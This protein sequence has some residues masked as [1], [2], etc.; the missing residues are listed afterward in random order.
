MEKRRFNKGFTLIELIV[1]IAILGILVLIAAPK[2]LGYVAEAEEAKIKHDVKVMEQEME[3]TSLEIEMS[4]WQTNDKD[5]S[6]LIIENKLFEKQGVAE[7]IDSGHVQRNGVLLES[8]VDN[9][10]ASAKDTSSELGMGGDLIPIS[11]EQSASLFSASASSFDIDEFNISKTYKIIPDEYKGEIDTSLDGTFYT[12]SEK[13]VYYEAGIASSSEKE[14]TQ[15]NLDCE[16]AAPDYD[17]EMVGDF[18]TITK[19]YGTELN[20]DIPDSFLL[21]VDGEEECVPVTVIGKA[22][23]MNGQFKSVTIPTSV[24][25]IEEYAFQNTKI[26]SIVIPPSVDSVGEGAFSGVEWSNSGSGSGSG[27]GSSSG[28]GVVILKR[29][30]EISIGNGAFGQH[31]P[32]YRAPSPTEAGVIFHPGS[33]TIVSGSPTR[34][35]VTVTVPSYISVGGIEYP[36]K[37]IKE[38]AYQ[39]QGIISV[40]LPSG[41]LRIEDYAFAGNQLEGITIPKSVEHIGNYAFAFNEVEET[42]TK[43]KKG[44]IKFVNIM[45]TEQFSKIDTATGNI[46]ENGRKVNSIAGDNYIGKV[47]LLSNIFVTGIVGNIVFEN[48]APSTPTITMNPEKT[49]VEVGTSVKLTASGSVD[50]DGDEI[51]Y[52]W[53]GREKET[54]TYKLGQNIVQVRAVDSRGAVSAWTAK[55][56]FVVDTRNEKGGMTLTGPYSTIHEKGLPNATITKFTFIVPPVS[57]HNSYADY[58]KVDGFNIKTGAWEQVYRANDVRNGHTATKSLTPGVYSELKMTYYTD[59]DCMYNKSNITYAV[60]YYFTETE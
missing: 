57:G 16:V 19:W 27:S 53:E 2:A 12:N 15:S 23:F 52:E 31:T 26:T 46:K 54:N 50:E 59:H 20:L 48:N 39:G 55:S 7:T 10:F 33:G 56:F 29:T 43:E 51:T 14:G 37:T 1:T 8:S 38:G 49:F 60:D 4:G 17:F 3:L 45:G 30:E 34:N 42:T 11:S 21:E 28:D 32:T 18:G 24:R 36:V 47:N 22:A 40:R 5:L 6:M 13:K 44:T 35:S 41:L 9:M 58:A 25:I